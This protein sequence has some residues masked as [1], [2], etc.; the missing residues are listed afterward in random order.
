MLLLLLEVLSI[1]WMMRWKLLALRWSPRMIQG[2][3]VKNY[4]GKGR[5]RTKS[6]RLSLP[7]VSILGKFADRSGLVTRWKLLKAGWLKAWKM[8]WETKRPQLYMPG[9]DL[10]FNTWTSMRPMVYNVFHWVNL[11]YI[12]T[13]RIVVT[14]LL[15]SCGPFCC[16]WVSQTFILGWMEP[17]RCSLLGGSEDVLRST[18]LR[19]GSLCSDLLWQCNRW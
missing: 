12:I 4:P 19:L 1:H 7:R 17:R 5:Q 13:W 3:G 6:G 15:H 8:H 14:N 18:M 10:W 11:G 2:Y 9:L 16:R